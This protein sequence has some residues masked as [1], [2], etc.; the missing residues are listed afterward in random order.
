MTDEGNFLVYCAEI[1][2]DNKGITGKELTE[3][4]N[5]YKIWDFLYECYGALHTNGELYII[6]D[7]DEFIK[8]R[9]L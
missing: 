4:F 9:S 1:Y 7:I 3:L 8:V 5:K 6:N 2:K